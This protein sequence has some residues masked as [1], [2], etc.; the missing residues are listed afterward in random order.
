MTCD[1]AT[2]LRRV[3]TGVANGRSAVVLD[4][5]PATAI[6]F[7]PGVGLYEIWTDPGGAL[8]REGAPSPSM[9][10]QVVL[11]PPSGGVKLRWFS[12]GPSAGKPASDD[13][14]AFFQQA[15]AAIGATDEQPDTNRH[16]GMHLTHTLDFIIVIK[17][18]V[19]LLLDD[20]DRLLGPGDVVVQRGTNHAWVSEGETPALLVAVLI[21][22]PFA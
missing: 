13:T 12:V 8:I 4:G 2:T 21:D 22:K 5:P 6:E 18:S 11:S 3:V 19:R 16:P 20:D 7:Q 9:A 14:K 17:G 15:F 10:S 1:L